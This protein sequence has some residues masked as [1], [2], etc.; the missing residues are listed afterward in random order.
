MDKVTICH[1]S[2]T[3]SSTPYVYRTRDSRK[4]QSRN[5]WFSKWKTTINPTRKWEKDEQ[6]AL[7]WLRVFKHIKLHATNSIWFFLFS[8]SLISNAFEHY[9][10]VVWGKHTMPMWKTEKLREKTN[11]P[12]KHSNNVVTI[13]L[14][15]RIIEQHCIPMWIN[16]VIKKKQHQHQASALRIVLRK[17]QPHLKFDRQI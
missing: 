3:S 10:H 12:T 16:S 4:T 15:R 6:S 5:K 14:R 8:C 9:T 13:C 17:E 2:S 11:Q 7:N 1:I